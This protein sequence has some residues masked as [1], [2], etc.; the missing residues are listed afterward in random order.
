MPV[1][2]ILATALAAASASSVP[3][4]DA[5]APAAAKASAAPGKA[6][7]PKAKAPKGAEPT[8]DSARAY[9]YLKEQ[10]AFGP[11]VAESEA[12]RKALDYFLAHFRGL[13]FET[14]R[15]DFVHTDMA[16]GAKV[17]MTNVLVTVPGRDLKR[18][19]V[20]FC[21]HWDSRPRADQEASEMLAHQPIT[22][23]NDGA[24][25]AAVLMELANGM[26]KNPPLQTVRLALFDGED[27]G[28]EG[29]LD[30]Y[31]LGARYF[32]DNPP[33]S[34]WEYALLLDM[35]GDKDLHLPMEQNSVK[36]SPGLV[37]KIWL[38]A[39]ELGIAQFEA[40]LGP[41]VLDDHMPLQDKGIPAVDI[42]DF[43][44]PA[45]H[46]QG[47]TPDK[48]SAASLGA[49]GRLLASLAHRGLD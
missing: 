45:W 15:Q 5:G 41:A 4:A 48:C 22:G 12:H 28:K 2:W 46:T 31:F 49:V 18:K 26:K 19:P 10:C 34:G 20:L 23:A 16:T 21:A 43:E 3:S 44:Y 47:D 36:Q 32:A 11:R 6:S 25:G 8:F 24:S 33:A 17:P 35:I 39:K 30:E 40:R 42:I 14:A 7:A 1:A 38:R 13:G 29:N 27:Y 37:T 9:R